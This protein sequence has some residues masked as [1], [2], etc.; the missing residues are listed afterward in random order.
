[1]IMY[2]V[3]ALSNNSLHMPLMSRCFLLRLQ[4]L[5]FLAIGQA[6]PAHYNGR[7]ILREGKERLNHRFVVIIP[8][9]LL[10]QLSSSRYPKQ[11]IE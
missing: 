11:Y 10:R 5:R 7:F 1:M 2:R 9:L 3:V 8:Y 4:Y 6:V